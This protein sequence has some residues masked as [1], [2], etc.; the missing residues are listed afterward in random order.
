LVDS[1]NPTNGSLRIFDY[2]G[3]L[4]TSAQLI[5]DDSL[6][7]ANVV[8]ISYYG[9]GR[10]RATASFENGLIR[11][12]GLYTNTDGHVSSDKRIQDGTK[13][14]G[15]SY[16]INTTKDYYNFKN[17]LNN[18]VHPTGTKTFVNRIDI[19]SESVDKSITD[20]T[21]IQ[22]SLTDTFNVSNGSNN[23][24]STNTSAN[25][26][27]TVN[28]GDI[29]ILTSVSKRISG[30]ANTTSGSNTIIGVAS[31]FINDIIEG[32]TIYISTGNTVITSNVVNAT[33]IITQNT[34]NVTNTGAT[35][36]VVFN[37]TK[38]VTFVNANTILVD[39]SFST[40]SNFVTT[41]VQKIE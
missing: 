15:F 22:V 40:N 30:T 31:N 5:S 34:I 11:L 41:L 10:A 16:I 23:M 20:N 17:A 18:L 1:Y 32:D 21:I 28:V 3:S 8:G 19:N 36:D 29:V 6:V 39:T 37:D 2:K 25:V 24:V 26:A 4:D 13:Y 33:C 7:T 38:V 35:I 27:S 9:D 14:H 12:P